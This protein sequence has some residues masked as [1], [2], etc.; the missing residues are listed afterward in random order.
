MNIFKIQLHQGI[1]IVAILGVST[2]VLGLGNYKASDKIIKIV[3]IILAV[4]TVMA[5]VYAFSLGM[6]D[7][8]SLSGNFDWANRIDILFLIAFM[9]WMPAPIDGS[10]WYS[11]WSTAKENKL[12]KILSMRQS[13]LDFN[14][15]YIG[16]ALL[17]VCFL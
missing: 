16:A 17:G 15:G 9:G 12:G 5:V 7:T 6:F 4:S 2:V 8:F 13:L 11:L 3:I 14:I 1:V 10:F